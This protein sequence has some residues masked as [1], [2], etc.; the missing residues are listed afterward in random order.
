V[1]ERARRPLALLAAVLA[2]LL[3]APV[4]AEA[5]TVYAAA[6]LREAF[7]RIAPKQSYDF[8]GSDQLQ[9]QIERGAPADVFASAAPRQAQALFHEGLC[10]RPVTFATNVVVLLV[11]NG[12]PGN[13]HSVYNL[14]HGNRR[15]AVGTAT[16]PIGEYTRQLLARMRLSSILTTNTV[17]LEPN[18]SGITSKVALGAV[19][20][21]FAYLTDGRIV[22]DRTEV[23]RL[24]LWAQPPVRY[25]ACVVHRP[26]ADEADAQ[27]FI[28]AVTGRRGRAILEQGGFGLPPR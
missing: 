7:P 12:N 17:S 20:A 22:A 21:G 6:S 27:R 19:E 26:G 25:Q 4:G 11:P 5:I 15:L 10:S 13:I 3:A 18:V 2:L 28:A 1:A 8:A 23:I 9:T 16:V 24:P 14:R